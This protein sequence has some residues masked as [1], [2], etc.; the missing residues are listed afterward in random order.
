MAPELPTNVKII[1]DF[2]RAGN[3]APSTPGAYYQDDLADAAHGFAP[4]LRLPNP[5]GILRFLVFGRRRSYRGFAGTRL[6]I[7]A[8]ESPPP[9]RLQPG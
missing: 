4:D 1:R 9:R 8:G 5:A 7:I 2:S 3:A 6:D